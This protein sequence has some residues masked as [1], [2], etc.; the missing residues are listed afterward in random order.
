MLETTALRLCAQM[1]TEVIEV[2]DEGL[3]VEILK[4]YVA[5]EHGWKWVADC[6]LCEFDDEG[7]LYGRVCDRCPLL[8]LWGGWSDAIYQCIQ[9]TSPYRLICTSHN[10]HNYKEIFIENANLIVDE[11]NNQ[12]NWWVALKEMNN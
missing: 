8:K 4:H 2:F 9:P 6:V 7:G 11:C 1:W 12:L 3:D 10:L 5:E